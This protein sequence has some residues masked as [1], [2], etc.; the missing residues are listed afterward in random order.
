[1][2]QDES[3][4]KAAESWKRR[5]EEDTEEEKG[6]EHATYPSV[7]L[8]KRVFVSFLGLVFLI[9]GVFIL[10]EVSLPPIMLR[11][12]GIATD[13]VINK[14]VES[15]RAPGPQ[16]GE[17][18]YHVYYSFTVPTGET[19][20]EHSQLNADSW[21]SLKQNQT[22]RVFY[23]PNDP[24]TNRLAADYPQYW[25]SF[26]IMI[27]FTPLFGGTGILLLLYAVRPHLVQR[28]SHKFHG[29]LARFGIEPYKRKQPKRTHE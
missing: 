26:L 6:R 29:F 2:K 21:A 23:L 14:L 5:Q 28:L 12:R 27:I 19:I 22:V 20:E 9:A 13:G 10:L 4:E 18:K 25:V 7:D 16:G 1:M 17:S 3:R 24:Q 11:T 8:G 15:T